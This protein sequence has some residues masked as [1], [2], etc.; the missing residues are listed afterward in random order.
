MATCGVNSLFASIHPITH[1]QS[2]L[3]SLQVI[4]LPF[5]SSN[6]GYRFHAPSI[7][8][9]SWHDTDSSSPATCI[10]TRSKRNNVGFAYFLIDHDQ[11]AKWNEMMKIPRHSCFHSIVRP[12]QRLPFNPTLSSSISTQDEE[13]V[14]SS[15]LV[16]STCP[17][18]QSG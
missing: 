12:P 13:Q 9:K 17:S 14:A 4:T 15:V 16:C 10:P 6:D 3:S 8:N 5:C 11:V 1:S 7:Q 2:A 18:V